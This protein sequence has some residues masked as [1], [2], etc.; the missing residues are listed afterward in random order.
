MNTPT[1]EAVCVADPLIA[2]APVQGEP[3]APP[4]LALQLL[5][6]GSLQVRLKLV[7][8][9]GAEVEASNT[10]PGASIVTVTLAVAAGWFGSTPTQEIENVNAPWKLAGGWN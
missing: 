2:S 5:A 8:I 4:P 1:T 7:P 3:L 10:T 9:T 6:F